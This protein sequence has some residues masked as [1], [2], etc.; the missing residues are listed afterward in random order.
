MNFYLCRQ[1]AAGGTMQSKFADTESPFGALEFMQWNHPWNSFKYPSRESLEKAAGLMKEAGISIVRFDFLWEDIEPKPGNFNFE[2][3]DLIVD[4][5]SEN[6]IKILGIFDY[7]A[8]W[9]AEDGQWNCVPRDNALFVNYA[10]RVIGRYKDKVKYWE[11][12]NEPDSTTYWSRQDGLK[13]Y[14]ALLKDVYS[15]AKLVDPD[16]RIL[17]GGL[18]LG[19]ASV[20]RLYDNGAKNYFDILNIHIFENPLYPGRDKAVSAYPK[21]ARKIMERNNDANKEIWITEIG[22]PGVKKGID[23]ADWWLGKNPDEKQQ[24]EWVKKVYTELLNQNLVSKI[25]WAFLRDCNNHWGTGVDYFGLVR[26]DFSPKP[27]FYSYKEI[28]E[29]WIRSSAE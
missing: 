4:V 28:A 19:P 2:K 16:C 15:A 9:A 18:A 7:C 27:A 21:L 3:Y 25:F 22:C 20:N 17:N 13:S 24:A 26:W 29:E 5:L 10:V 14:C 6:N 11:V 8:S 12:W 1:A 23:I